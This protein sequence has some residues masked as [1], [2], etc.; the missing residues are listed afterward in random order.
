VDHIQTFSSQKYIEPVIKLWLFFY[1]LLQ[2]SFINDQNIAFLKSTDFIW[3]CIIFFKIQSIQITSHVACFQFA[4]HFFTDLDSQLAHQHDQ[5]ELELIIL[6]YHS[7]VSIELHCF[8]VFDQCFQI[9]DLQNIEYLVIFP[10]IVQTSEY[11]CIFQFVLYFEFRHPNNT[12]YQ[13]TTDH[14]HYIL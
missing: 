7:C 12:L 5:Q 2:I 4:D 10:E 1:H 13:P 3:R 6:F 11:F 8:A 14:Q 9:I